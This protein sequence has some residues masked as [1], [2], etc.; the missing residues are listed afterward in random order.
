MYLMDVILRYGFNTQ[1]YSLFFMDL[2][3]SN[4]INIIVSI[5]L[6]MPIIYITEVY[7]LNLL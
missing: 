7:L 1:T 3:K 6:Y 4:A 2:I 5:L